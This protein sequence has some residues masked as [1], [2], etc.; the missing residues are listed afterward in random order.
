MQDIQVDEL[1][2]MLSAKQEFILLDVRE[3]IEFHTFNVG[4]TN[5]PLGNL[6][7]NIDDLDVEKDKNIVVICQHGIRS[8]TA[9]QVLLRAGFINVKNV[10]GGIANYYKKYAK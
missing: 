5:I 8:K 6:I 9:Q 4:G 10:N 1:H 7:T 2:T 3:K